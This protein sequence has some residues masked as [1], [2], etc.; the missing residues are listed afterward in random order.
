MERGGIS[1]KLGREL[2]TRCPYEGVPH[3]ESS[4]FN[5]EVRAFALD[6]TLTTEFLVFIMDNGIGGWP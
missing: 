2:E 5:N 3:C 6:V 4:L 1:E